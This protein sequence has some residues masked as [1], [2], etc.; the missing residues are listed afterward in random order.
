MDLGLFFALANYDQGRPKLRQIFFEILKSKKKKE[1]YS[2]VMTID[3]ATCT[4]FNGLCYLYTI[5]FE[6]QI[7]FL[8]PRNLCVNPRCIDVQAEKGIFSGNRIAGT[9][10]ITIKKSN[11][12][13]GKNIFY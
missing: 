2:T 6:F 3:K 11:Q 10:P 9:R 5:F 8:Y 1:L 12:S 7:L 13:K 4:I